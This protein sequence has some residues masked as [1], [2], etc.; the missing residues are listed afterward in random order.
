[1]ERVKG[2]NIVTLYLASYVVIGLY[3][4]LTK[5]VACSKN[6]FTFLGKVN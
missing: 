3:W 4:P 5:V 1:M 6:L 2:R